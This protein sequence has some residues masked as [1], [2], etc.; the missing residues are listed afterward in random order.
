MESGEWRVESVKLDG[1]L[2][3]TYYFKLIVNCIRRMVDNGGG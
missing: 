1:L 2:A 3:Q